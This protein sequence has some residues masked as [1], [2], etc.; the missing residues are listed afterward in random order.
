MTNIV[1]SDTN[2]FTINSTNG[3]TPF[4][5]ETTVSKQLNVKQNFISNKPSDLAEYNIKRNNNPT[6]I[7]AYHLI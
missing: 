2:N 6:E 1:T 7:P 4:I 3:I 5:D